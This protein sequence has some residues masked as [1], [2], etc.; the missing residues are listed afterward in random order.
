MHSTHV[1]SHT[2]TRFELNLQRIC[3]LK[4]FHKTE[5]VREIFFFRISQQ[6]LLTSRQFRAMKAPLHHPW[7]IPEHGPA[8]PRLMQLAPI[9]SFGHTLLP[10]VILK[11]T[12]I[13]VT[14]NKPEWPGHCTSLQRWEGAFLKSIRIWFKLILQ[15]RSIWHMTEASTLWT[16]IPRRH[17]PRKRQEGISNWEGGG[18][19][20][21]KAYKEMEV[22]TGIG[23]Q[24][25]RRI[26]FSGNLFTTYNDKPRIIE[27][28][29]ALI[30]PLKS[31]VIISVST[32]KTD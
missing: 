22:F 28:V 25:Q 11:L 27:L 15:E 20:K 2:T 16:E 23:D 29:A 31:L 14:A 17:P 5:T 21:G 12:H 3:C 30:S 19:G 7:A 32:G 4:R 1:Q 18:K 24:L 9:S 13:Y 8:S 26:F 6:R 10:G